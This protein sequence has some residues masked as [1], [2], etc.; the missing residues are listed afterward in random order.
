MEYLP[1][2]FTLDLPNGTFPLSTDSMVLAHFAKLP[3]NA[4]I[5]DLGAGCGTLGVLLCSK[6]SFCHVTGIELDETAHLAALE[7]IRRNSLASRMESICGDL[8]SVSER[9]SPGSFSVCI[10]NP[11]YFSGGPAS[12]ATPLARRE[13]CCTPADLFRA[14]G[15]VLKFGGDFFLV[16]KPERLAQLI[17]EGSLAGL[18][19]KRL[20]LLRHKPESPVNLILLQ[21]RKGGK[22]GLL[23]EEIVLH[24]AD[25]TPSSLYQEIYH[26]PAGNGISHSP[27]PQTE[28]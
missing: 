9:F 3:R 19:A 1:N 13:D 5:L 6:N 21:F 23:W 17:S 28:A 4:R 7:N 27:Q 16:H 15:H 14:V 18:E 10:S 8:R 24:E 25:G 26:T 12:Q 2:G 20:C 22:S 11:P